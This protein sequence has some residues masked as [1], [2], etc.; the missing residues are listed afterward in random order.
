VVAMLDILEE[1]VQPPLLAVLAVA[2]VLPDI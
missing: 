1:M 2:A